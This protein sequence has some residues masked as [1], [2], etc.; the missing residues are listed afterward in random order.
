MPKQQNGEVEVIKTTYGK[1]AVVKQIPTLENKIKSD[2]E[3]G[4]DGSSK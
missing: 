3:L 1:K 2:A 4:I